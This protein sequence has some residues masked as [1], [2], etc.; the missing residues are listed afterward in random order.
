MI[1]QSKSDSKWS[2][3]IHTTPSGKKYV[4]ITSRKLN[5]RWRNGHGYNTQ[6]FGRAIEK[7]GWENIKHEVIAS[8]LTHDKAVELEKFLIAKY[9]TN[10][11]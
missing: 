1:C 7:Y 11:C 2:V 10:D 8:D 5:K 6:M 4:G 9:K 3:Y